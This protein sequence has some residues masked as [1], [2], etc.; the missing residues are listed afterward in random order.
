MKNIV[1]RPI[2]PYNP[3]E[4]SAVF[5]DEY[6]I[7]APIAANGKP[8][9][10]GFNIH[11]FDLRDGI[12]SINFETIKIVD[13]DKTLPSYIDKYDK[14]G[15]KT[16]NIIYKNYAHNINYYGDSYES[17]QLTQRYTYGN[18]LVLPDEAGQMEIF[19]TRIG[20]YW[21]RFVNPGDIPFENI[22]SLC[23]SKSTYELLQKINS[24]VITVDQNTRNI[25]DTM[26]RTESIEKKVDELEKSSVSKDI[27]GNVTIHGN[28]TVAGEIEVVNTN[29]SMTDAPI[30]LVNTA[31]LDGEAFDWTNAGFVILLNE[32][33]ENTCDAYGFIYNN[34]YE[35]PL[36]AKGVYDKKKGT[37]SPNSSDITFIPKWSGDTFDDKFVYIDDEGNLVTSG[38]GG[39]D[40][41]RNTNNI[42]ENNIKITDL[43]NDVARIDRIVEKDTARLDEIEEHL[44]PKYIITDD[45]TAYRKD[46]PLKACSKA[47]LNSIGGMTYKSNNLF[48]GLMVAGAWLYGNGNFSASSSGYVT[49]KNKIPII[50]GKQ[51]TL[52]FYFNGKGTMNG[53]VFYKA[54]GTFISGDSTLRTNPCTFTVPNEASF[55]CFNVF[56]TGITV[57]DVNWVMLNEGATALPYEPYFDGFRH[58]SVTELK[59][60]GKNLYSGSQNIALY[61]ASPSKTTIFTADISET[62]T[63][64]YKWRGTT[65][66]SAGLFVLTLADGTT[67]NIPPTILSVTA[68]GIR[69]IA[70]PNWCGVTG[71]VYDI[72][73]E[74]GS[75]ATEYIPYK[76]ETIFQVPAEIQALPNYGKMF[77]ELDLVNKKYYNYYW[78]AEDFGVQDITKTTSDD[79]T[80]TDYTCYFSSNFISNYDTIGLVLTEKPYIS[81][82]ISGLDFYLKGRSSSIPSD[83][84][85]D[86]IVNELF[87]NISLIA[88]WKDYRPEDDGEY[89]IS[90]YIDS[91]IIKVTAGGSIE[92]VSDSKKA[93]PS[94]VSYMMGGHLLEKEV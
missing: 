90:D 15:K 17:P 38:Y 53:I 14:D 19:I 21:R 78:D 79:G 62:V 64:S 1:E 83:A 91:N 25:S 85:N 71:N 54:D 29:I 12:V 26:V 34:F 56:Q 20:I 69:K 70:L 24:I 89:D 7:F 75:K 81:L 58:S 67:Q 16:P 35:K 3:P 8:G 60:Y 18:L 46:V 32:G 65:V 41:H 80:Y 63:F 6:N 55:F 28:L 23:I 13:L 52:S 84:D 51:Y 37:F 94:S 72:Q 45:K 87:G 22:D 31:Y 77:T 86:T 42:V 82:E 40:I 57:D 43:E 49:N 88:R 92:F 39:S 68:K 76:E 36:I 4:S 30:A 47:Q 27:N 59:A 11:D 5:K 48:D 44:A 66:N 61:G 73:L 10:A 2:V 93:V 74:Y 33:N 9:M 50:G